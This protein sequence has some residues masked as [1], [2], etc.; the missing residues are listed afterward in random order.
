MSVKY[1]QVSKSVILTCAEDIE[2]MWLWSKNISRVILLTGP[3]FC[4]NTSRGSGGIKKIRPGYFT[5]LKEL[6]RVVRHRY[7]IFTP[8][9]LCTFPVNINPHPLYARRVNAGSLS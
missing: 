4:L 2:R 9:H 8:L 3:K 1:G 5:P 7:G 6:R